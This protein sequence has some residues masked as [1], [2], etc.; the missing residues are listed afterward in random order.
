MI[1][2]IPHAHEGPIWYQS[3]PSDVP[4]SPNQFL[5]LDFFCRFL[6]Q[7]SSNWTS[8]LF[9]GW[10][11]I[12]EW[13][14]LYHNYLTPILLYFSRLSAIALKKH[15]AETHEKY[16]QVELV[17]KEL[18]HFRGLRRFPEI[19]HR[20]HWQVGNNPLFMRHLSVSP[21]PNLGKTTRSP[22]SDLTPWILTL[23]EGLQHMPSRLWNIQP[24][25][26]TS[27]H[28]ASGKKEN[29]IY[30]MLRYSYWIFISVFQ[31]SKHA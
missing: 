19:G 20:G 16:L 23:P 2:G 30:N 5:S 13:N 8:L 6:Q 24:T 21:V 25:Q 26:R 22:Q 17:S 10:D 15:S 28:S 27:K 29:I 12:Y 1:K 31:Y 11:Q 18:N 4:C 3:E 7:D 9:W 14:Q